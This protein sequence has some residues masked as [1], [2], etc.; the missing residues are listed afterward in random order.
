VIKLGG[1]KLGGLKLGGL[2][3]L[4]CDITLRLD[5]GLFQGIVVL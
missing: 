1:R 2:K 4:A 5:F 3:L